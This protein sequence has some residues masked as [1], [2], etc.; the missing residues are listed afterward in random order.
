MLYT[1]LGRGEM[2]ARCYT[3]FVSASRRRIMGEGTRIERPHMPTW[4]RLA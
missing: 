4:A 3:A 1:L 2:S